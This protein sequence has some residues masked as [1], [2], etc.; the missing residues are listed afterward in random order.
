MRLPSQIERLSR[1]RGDG[2]ADAAWCS[3]SARGLLSLL[4][5]AALGFSAYLAWLSF[6][7]GTVAGCDA[8]GVLD[9]DHV[10]ST[11]WSTWLGVP[12]ALP[13]AM[14]YASIL[15]AVWFLGPAVPSAVRRVAWPIV[16]A[17]TALAALAAMWFVG[18][19]V[20]VI[21]RLCWPCLATHG[22][23]LLLAG[24]AWAVA[25]LASSRAGASLGRSAIVTSG[26][27]LVATGVLVGG[28]LAYEPPSFRIDRDESPRVARA[29]KPAADDG[30][31]GTNSL[32]AASHDADAAG[33]GP[34]QRRAEK[35]A[36]SR[37]LRL[38][39]TA[40]T[41]DAYEHPILGSPDAEH[42]IV[43]LFDYTCAH[44]RD[45]HFQLEEARQLFGGRLAILVLPVPMNRY[46]NPHATASGSG[47]HAQACLYARLAISVWQTDRTK[48]AEFHHWLFEPETPHPID[49][50]RKRVGE[51]AG[52]AAIELY[53][54]SVEPRQAIESYTSLYGSLDKGKIP[55]LVDEHF[56]I[57]GRFRDGQQIFDVLEEQWK[58]TR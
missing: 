25:W 16:L 29:D 26:I 50:V 38:R 58:T 1:H 14:V 35:P 53:D 21:G 13:A 57:D 9:C 7:G 8:G 52:S 3:L 36:L 18:L 15:S 27:A 41:F 17:L 4:A 24:T 55:K 54:Q 43:K 20:L 40:M 42:V 49:D 19:Q 46:C 47:P 23:G 12:I 48:F 5:A 11:R 28:Q 22:S 39:N 51:V 45:Q 33:T 44:C 10:L 6:N 31:H 32:G 56:V 34:T 30:S 37:I 2:S